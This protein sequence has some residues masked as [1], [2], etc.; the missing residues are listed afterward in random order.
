MTVLFLVAIIP[1]FIY[2][3]MKGNKSLHMLQQNWY[4]EG[5]RYLRWMLQNKYKV[6]IDPDMFFVIFIY[7]IISYIDIFKHIIFNFLDYYL[8]F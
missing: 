8:V 7:L 5:N 3:I 1:C 6:L 4:N 2:Y